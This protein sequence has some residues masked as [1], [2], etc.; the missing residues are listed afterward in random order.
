MR[1]FCESEH[2]K[3]GRSQGLLLFKKGYSLKHTIDEAYRI[4]NCSNL[5][6]VPVPE[7]VKE[8]ITGCIDQYCELDF[9][10][11]DANYHDLSGYPKSVGVFVASLLAILCIAFF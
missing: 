11:E 10:K 9:K 6:S 8:Y 5:A 1:E 7:P 3:K 4:N 2:Y